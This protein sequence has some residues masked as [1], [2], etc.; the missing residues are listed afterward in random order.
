MATRKKKSDVIDEEVAVATT[1]VNEY[2]GQIVPGWQMRSVRVIAKGKGFVGVDFNGF[3]VKI[4][5]ED[6]GK[7]GDSV[8]VQYKGSIGSSDFKIGLV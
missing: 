8:T 3:G 1:D 6:S 4:D 5:I 2:D 7:L